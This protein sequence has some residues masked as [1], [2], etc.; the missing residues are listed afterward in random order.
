MEVIFNT[1]VWVL[2]CSPH[3]QVE[4]GTNGVA[5]L[6]GT[7]SRSHCNADFQILN[8]NIHSWLTFSTTF[9]PSSDPLK[10]GWLWGITCLFGE[11]TIHAGSI[12]APKLTI[13]R[14]GSILGSESVSSRQSGRFCRLMRHLSQ[15]I[16]RVW[17]LSCEFD[18]PPRLP[19]L[20]AGST[21]HWNLTWSN[22]R[23]SQVGFRQI[24]GYA[25]A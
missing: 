12:W 16:Y 4:A 13:W 20:S 15:Q 3:L 7:D 19:V 11:L 5:K 18:S 24:R 22:H 2:H 10:R 8:A 1:W 9:P 23:P 14:F 17:L 25:T 21:D 6:S